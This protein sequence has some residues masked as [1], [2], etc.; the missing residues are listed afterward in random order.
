MMSS[1]V[2]ARRVWS[3]KKVN[4]APS[5]VRN[6]AETSGASVEITASLQ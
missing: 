4:V 2:I 5:P 6:A 3:D 1:S